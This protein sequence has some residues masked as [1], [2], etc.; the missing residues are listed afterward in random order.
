MKDII[1]LNGAPGSGKSTIA[2]LLRKQLK[3]PEAHFGYLRN[4]HLTPKDWTKNV[5]IGKLS[6]KE[7]KM[8]FQNIVFIVRNYLR[9]GY[10]NV[11]V[12]DLGDDYADKLARTFPKNKVIIFTLMPDDA[13]IRAR[14]KKR[15]SGWKN[16]TKAVFWNRYR[17]ARKLFKNEVMLD[18]NPSP[19]TILPEILKSI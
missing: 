8:S 13:V 17:R 9:H 12:H 1:I 10:K 2:K 18:A 16:S 4:F 6:T 11:I 3:S 14:I 19:K 15:N 5:G 7:R